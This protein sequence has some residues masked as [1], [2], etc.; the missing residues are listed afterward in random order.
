MLIKQGWLKFDP[1]D[2]T[3]VDIDSTNYN[4]HGT[5]TQPVSKLPKTGVSSFFCYLGVRSME[6]G[7]SRFSSG[8]SWWIADITSYTPTQLN[9]IF[10]AKTD[11][12]SFAFA[13]V[14]YFL[15][16]QSYTTQKLIMT[17]KYY[18]PSPWTTN[19]A[20]KNGIVQPFV[21]INLP[22]TLSHTNYN[23]FASLLKLSL[24]GN[25]N[26][27]LP[28]GVTFL[29][30]FPVT[31][32]LNYIRLDIQMRY[33]H[34]YDFTFAILLIDKA[35]FNYDRTKDLIFRKLPNNNNSVTVFSSPNVL[36]FITFNND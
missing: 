29:K 17:A 31:P 5:F 18:S 24:A 34:M 10:V 27:A 7:I 9:L 14:N 12:V 33:L 25:D 22:V 2:S 6:R 26:T 23:I 35:L 11:T 36:N 15:F 32:P 16:D 30:S 13:T 8:G 21:N 20:D 4:Y 28:I 3:I 1:T 19:S